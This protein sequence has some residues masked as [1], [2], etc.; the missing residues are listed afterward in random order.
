V[1]EL[2]VR[3]A[4]TLNGGPHADDEILAELSAR[5]DADA[6]WW[7]PAL[8]LPPAPEPVMAKPVATTQPLVARSQLQ[9]LLDELRAEPIRK[10]VI[11]IIVL[12]IAAIIVPLVSSSPNGMSATEQATALARHLDLVAR[13][14]PKG[15]RVDASGAGPLSGF[16]STSTSSG[17]STPQQSKQ[18]SAVASSFEQCMGI[19]SAQDRVFGPAI[20]TP[21]AQVSSAAFV[22]PADAGSETGTTASVFASPALLSADLALASS[23]KFPNCF[24]TA[25]GTLFVQGIQAAQSGVAPGTPQVQSLSLSQQKGTQTVGETIT[26]PVTAGGHD[27]SIEVGVVFIAAGRAEITLFTYSSL[28]GFP[29]PLRATL[30]TA[31]GQRL[32][33]AKTS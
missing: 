13:D 26:I 16:L 7:S 8:D 15:W 24:G 9:T 27:F 25:I 3:G 20:T 29:A 14:L 18:A 1:V 2:G 23:S 19:S 10:L 31:L 4:T 5:L 33:A 28:S 6:L 12:L 22:S 17:P 21:E 32:A 11:A 30:A